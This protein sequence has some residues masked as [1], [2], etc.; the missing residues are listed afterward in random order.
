MAKDFV[1]KTSTK[2]RRTVRRTV[3]RTIR[4]RQK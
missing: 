4:I 1:H 2:I 3:K